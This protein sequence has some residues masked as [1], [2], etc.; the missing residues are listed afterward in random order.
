MRACVCACVVCLGK[1]DVIKCEVDLW[2]P[3]TLQTT[4]MSVC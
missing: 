1:E 2:S 4:L 3:V